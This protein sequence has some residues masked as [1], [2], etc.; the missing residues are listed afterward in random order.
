MP[1]NSQIIVWYSKIDCNTPW[2]N[3]AWYGV[4][5]VRNRSFA[6]T[7]FTTAGM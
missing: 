4:Y 1:V 3:S 5:V 7:V 2:L 6:V